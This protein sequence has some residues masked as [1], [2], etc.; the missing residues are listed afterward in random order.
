MCTGS[1]SLYVAMSRRLYETQ[2]VTAVD[3]KKGQ[4]RIPNAVF[5]ALGIT[6]GSQLW[7]FSNQPLSDAKFKEYQGSR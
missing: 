5:K 4:I 3:I 7:Q 2:T 6:T 1:H